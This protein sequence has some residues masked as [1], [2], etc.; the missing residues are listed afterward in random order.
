MRL[1]ERTL[2]QVRIAPR[3]AAQGALGSVGEAFSEDVRCV[4]ASLL[5]C[6]GELEAD[7]RGAKTGRRLR[8]MTARDVQVKAGDGVW[9][10][11]VLWRIVAAEKWSAHLELVCEEMT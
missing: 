1:K 9:V 6:G 10:E 7:A 4:R 11:D 2:V 3:I 8:L 5:P